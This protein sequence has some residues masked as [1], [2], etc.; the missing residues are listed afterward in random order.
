MPQPKNKMSNTTILVEPLC[1]DFEHVSFNTAILQMLKET[2]PNNHFLFLFDTRYRIELNKEVIANSQLQ[3]E[4]INIANRNSRSTDRIITDFLVVLK[5]IRIA[6]RRNAFLIFTSSNI[7]SLISA[8]LL[9]R[10]YPKV[11]ILFV[12]HSVLE[13]LG[14]RTH[15]HPIKE[16]PFN[17]KFWIPRL[18]N[19][20]I[21]YLLLGEHILRNVLHLYPQLANTLIA[22]DPP[23]IFKSSQTYGIDHK[24][25]L[26]FGA[27]GVGH[28]N[29]G[30]DIFFEL[31]KHQPNKQSQNK[32][33]FVLVGHIT[34]QVLKKRYAKNVRI[35]SNAPLSETEYEQGVKDIDYAV[36]CYHRDSYRFTASAAFLDAISFAKPI[37]AIKNPFFNYYFRLLGK[38]GYLCNTLEEMICLINHPQIRD[39]KNYLGMVN[40]ILTN[41]QQIGL[42]NIG[43][44]LKQALDLRGCLL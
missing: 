28:M 31:A 33:E 39:N 8:H 37:I 11:K 43:M 18:I 7:T 22:I 12:F 27:L 25:T 44:K 17:T 3:I 24:D 5:A 36:F 6:Q 14:R 34:D 15:L 40:N 19:R 4:H 1:T 16:L 35:L 21:F 30:T 41:R 20:N 10:I 38:I 9:A 42:S 2:Y 26:R 23:Y 29:K 13:D 32:N